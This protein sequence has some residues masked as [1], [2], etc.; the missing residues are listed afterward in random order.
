MMN[1]EMKNNA[2]RLLTTDYRLLITDYCL[3]PTS[4]PQGNLCTQDHVQRLGIALVHRLLSLVKRILR[5]RAV[6][7]LVWPKVAFTCCLTAIA[8][9]CRLSGPR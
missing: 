8:V 6:A 3:L 7:S 5:T 2:Y 4:L 1:D 9:A